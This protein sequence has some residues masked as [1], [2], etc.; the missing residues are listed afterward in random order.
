M[1]LDIGHARRGGGDE[2]SGYIAWL[3]LDVCI[4]NTYRRQRII[5]LFLLLKVRFDCCKIVKKSAVTI[6]EDSANKGNIRGGGETVHVVFNIFQ[7]E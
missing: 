4:L 7:K 5:S 3:Q 2:T 1:V 6:M